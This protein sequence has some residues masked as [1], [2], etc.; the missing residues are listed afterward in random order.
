L[1]AVVAAFAIRPPG[2]EVAEVFTGALTTMPEDVLVQLRERKIKSEELR[3]Y[4]E[5]TSNEI[6]LRKMQTFLQNAI[7]SK[8]KG[9]ELEKL[10]LELDAVE[11]ELA[12]ANLPVSPSELPERPSKNDFRDQDEQGPSECFGSNPQRSG[13]FSRG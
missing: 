3:Q 9:S 1:L 10:M 7:L 5:F 8:Y 13:L 4:I 12:K 2:E 11:M 6:F